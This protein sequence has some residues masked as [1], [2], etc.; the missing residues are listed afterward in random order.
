V[1]E[2]A[3]LCT[4]GGN[5]CGNQYGGSWKKVTIALPYGSTIPFLGIYLKKCELGYSRVTCTPVFIAA[6]FIIAK[7]GK[8]PKWHE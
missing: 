8:Q 7:S 2:K 1:G 3:P 6:L 5:C 4:I